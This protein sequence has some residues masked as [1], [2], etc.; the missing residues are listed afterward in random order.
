MVPRSIRRVGLG[1]IVTSLT[2][3]ASGGA[4][5]APETNNHLASGATEAAA[6]SRARVSLDTAVTRAR[7]RMR[8]SG[9]GSAGAYEAANPAQQLYATFSLEGITL[10]RAEAANT[11]WKW[12]L[13]LATYGY[14][15][16]MREIENAAIV[17]LANR[18]ECRRGPLTEW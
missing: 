18:I 17:A 1:L 12:S 13:S 14:G 9:R 8:T 11:A 6:A 5:A 7:Y 15:P 3:S 2:L 4:V 10:Q 16:R